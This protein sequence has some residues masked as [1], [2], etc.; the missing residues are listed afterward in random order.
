[1]RIHA[2]HGILYGPT[3]PNAGDL[4][5]QPYDQ[6]NDALAAELHT[7]DEHHFT[8]LSKPVQGTSPSIY[9]EA[10]RV[11]RAWLAEGAIARDPAPALYPYVIRLAEGGR[12]LG[13]MVLAGLEPPENG[14]IRPHEETLAKPLADRLALLEAMRVDLEPALL[15]SEDGGELDRLLEEDI[16][17]QAPV[18][19]A[20]DE[21]GHHH[22]L[23][24]V[25]DPARIARYREV[26]AGPAAIAD[27][28]HRYKV[29]LR[30]AEA[31]GIVGQDGPAASKLSVVTSLSSPALA[32]EPIHRALAS[33][34][35][36]EKAAALAV[37]R[38]EST[39]DSGLAFAAAVA[40]SAESGQP[41]LGV[42]RAGGRPEIWRLAPATATTHAHLSAGARDLPVALLHGVLLPAMGHGPETATDGTV[43]YR[44]DPD[45]LWGMV[46]RGEVGVGLWL[47]PMAPAQF[48]AAIA[49]GDLLPPKSTRFLPKVLSGL[50]WADHE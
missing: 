41:A 29:G 12:R 40:A 18:V 9:A 35:G 28:H 34:E 3:V 2:F 10:D 30:H 44:S 15:L 22:D 36:L 21:F 48:A 38:E 50:V 16:A 4:A 8:W 1:M 25:T 7:R 33:S 39:A 45:V 5:A 14:L 27:G 13:V 47:P 20:R 6:I 23:Y 24:R 19:T 26:M 43:I 42:F 49:H 11:H 46:T 17:G 32:I 31:H 37:S